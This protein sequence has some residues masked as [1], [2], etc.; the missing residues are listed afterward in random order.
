[1][2]SSDSWLSYWLPLPL[3]LPRTQS[4]R[5]A[6]PVLAPFVSFEL[7]FAIFLQF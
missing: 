6:A 5:A 4:P 2:A 1:M 3:P 7:G